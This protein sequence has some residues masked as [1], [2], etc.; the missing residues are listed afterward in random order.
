M[1]KNEKNLQSTK[2]DTDDKVRD[3][4]ITGGAVDFQDSLIERA[5]GQTCYSAFPEEGVCILSR[6]TRKEEPQEGEEKG[7]EHIVG[8]HP[9]G[10]VLIDLSE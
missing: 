9:V 3:F 6:Q 7:E 10:E 4:Q 8:I 5:Y 2:T 1:Q